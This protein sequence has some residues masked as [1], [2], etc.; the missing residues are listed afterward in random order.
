MFIETEEEFNRLSDDQKTAAVIEMA[1]LMREIFGEMWYSEKFE[2]QAITLAMISIRTITAPPLRVLH[3]GKPAIDPQVW[4]WAY[5]TECVKLQV[6]ATKTI[7]D[8]LASS[9][10]T[11]DW[12]KMADY[13]FCYDTSVTVAEGDTAKEGP[14]DEPPTGKG[15]QPE[16]EEKPEE[17]Q[18]RRTDGDSSLVS[19]VSKV[20]DDF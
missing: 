4:G 12:A 10:T 17:E 18:K 2:T 14:A 11:F 7:V 9:P 13:V 5:Y 19:Y 15:E 16:T 8:H 3:N 6:E 1:T 20:P